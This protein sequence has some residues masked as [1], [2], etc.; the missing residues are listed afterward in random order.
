MRTFVSP[1]AFT[2]A[3]YGLFS[4]V[5]WAPT[6]DAKW[7]LGVT[8]ESN[9]PSADSWLDSCI[10][11]GVGGGFALTK[12]AMWEREHRGATPFTV[13]SEVDCSP[14][15]FYD[16]A[17]T[18]ARVGLERSEQFQVEQVLWTGTAAG[19]A[20]GVYPHLAADAEVR[21]VSGILLQSAATI[22][23]GAALSV[24]NGLGLLERE[25]ATCYQGVGV[26]HIPMQAAPSL[27]NRYQIYKDTGP[28][29][30]RWRTANGNYVVFGAGYANT[31]PAGA[32]VGV[33][34]AWLYATGPVFGYR[35]DIKTFT[36]PE[37]L[38][39]T[40]NTLHM[41]AERDYVIGYDCCLLAVR[42]NL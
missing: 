10:V 16:S 32:S 35:S 30:P 18:A 36:R 38:D 27:S 1:P 39:R 17:E 12:A 11:S 3:N 25:L 5:E 33:G 13:Y 19:V 21:D 40:V 41:I 15:G 2:P 20:E 34:E 31:S 4:V 14:V 9:C 42:V 7:R 37:S 22:V 26:I 24:E 28:N 6:A 8:W 23:S 29:G